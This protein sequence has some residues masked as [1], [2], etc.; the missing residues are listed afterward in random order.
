M[1]TASLNKLNEQKFPEVVATYKKLIGKDMYINSIHTPFVRL[2]LPIL[3]SADHDERKVHSVVVPDFKPS[4][5]GQIKAAIFD[6]KFY[7]LIVNMVRGVSITKLQTGKYEFNKVQFGTLKLPRQKV[8]IFRANFYF[9]ELLLIAV[10]NLSLLRRSNI[11]DV[12]L[13]EYRVFKYPKFHSDACKRYAHI[14]F[15]LTP[16]NLYENLNNNLKIIAKTNICFSKIYSNSAYIDNDIFKL[17]CHYCTQRGSQ[18]IFGQHG[19]GWNLNKLS[20]ERQM[21]SDFATIVRFWTHNFSSNLDKFKNKINVKLKRFSPAKLD[22]KRAVFIEYAWPDHRVSLASLP[23]EEEVKAMYLENTIFF[24][25]ISINLEVA[26][27]PDFDPGSRQNFY[28][29]N[30]GDNISFKYLQN[31]ID[32]VIS[33]SNLIITSIP[34][35]IFYQA[36]LSNYPVVIWFAPGYEI[37]DHFQEL[38]KELEK[39]SIFHRSAISC[40]NFVN[41]VNLEAWWSS[42]IV[43]KNINKLKYSLLGY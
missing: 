24:Q 4:S 22:Y 12:I 31:S 2:L 7:E 10:K 3:I 21:I 11:P 40:A 32:T 38:F 35:T 39:C 33:Q 13:D 1:L 30:S 36:I 41:E 19:G 25:A 17:I 27:Y 37:D 23:Q 28:S 18:V 9:K 5:T 8:L 20:N 43:Q 16:T 15:S 6:K 42:D 34:N 14:I 29:K 26:L